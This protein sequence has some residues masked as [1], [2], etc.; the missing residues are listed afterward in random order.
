MRLLAL[1]LVLAVAACGGDG[2]A[3]ATDGGSGDDAAR[4]R[5]GGAGDGAAI[6]AAI[7]P[8]DAPA[9]VATVTV[10]PMLAPMIVTT[11]A[12]LAAELRDAGG[13]LLR[14]RAI[15]WTSSDPARLSVSAAGVVHAFAVG[16]PIEVSA[17]SE[18]AHGSVMIS[19][20]DG[21]I[22][23]ITDIRSFLA[24][25]P[26]ND[27]AYA[28]LRAD[29]EL[30]ADGVPIAGDPPCTEPYSTVPIAQL[31]DELYVLQVLRIAYYMS[32]GTESHLP[33]TS[34]GLYPWLHTRV[35]G[36]NLKAA[37]GQ[38]Y[39]CD[40]LD[41][42]L[43]FAMSR[44]SDFSRDF[45]RDWPGLS[46]SLA[47]FAH[48]IRHAD[49]GPGHVNGCPAFPQPSDPLG[50]DPSYDL[51]NLGSYGVQ[52]WLES[53][54]ANGSLYIGIPCAPPAVAQTYLANAVQEA[55]SFINR[56]VTN[57]PPTAT[58][59]RTYGGPCP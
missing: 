46:G 50:C 24:R 28:A 22:T 34:L 11:E 8:V 45:K 58:A 48:E 51:A 30:R 56:F 35:S 52:Y 32:P 59:R 13:N 31:T 3:R 55:N 23:G 57:A 17:T 16:G 38:L 54:W 19:V 33:W 2:G 49:P 4:A 29:F 6:D 7:V 39:C 40:Q 15:A 1:T 18:G 43:F 9:P 42:R 25:C 21:V 47:F 20:V 27:P 10:T 14:G 37:P 41:G 36:I 53:S 12:T 44:Q 26:T 5:D